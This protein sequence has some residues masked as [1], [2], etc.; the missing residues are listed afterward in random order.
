VFRK[1]RIGTRIVV[2]LALVTGLLALDLVSGLFVLGRLQS[3]SGAVLRERIPNHLSTSALCEGQADAMRAV[4]ALLAGNLPAD[5]R[6]ELYAQAD[7]AF[8]RIDAAFEDLG[9]QPKL[10]DAVRVWEDLESPWSRWRSA[11]SAALA[12]ERERD[13]IAPESPERAGADE[14]V[15]A[16][17]LALRPLHHDA[18]ARLARFQALAREG[19]QAGAGAIDSLILWSGIL[20]TAFFGV[21]AIPGFL[22]GR[23][24]T[25]TTSRIFSTIDQRLELLAQGVLSERLTESE[26]PDFDKVRDSL[27]G[28]VGSLQSLITEMNRMSAAHD[29]GDTDVIIDELRFAGEYRTVAQGLNRMVQAHVQESRKAIGIF[30]EFG[31]GNFDAALEPLPGKKRVINETVDQ[32]RTSL[33]SLIAEMNRMS[34]EHERGEIDAV[35]DESRFAGDY[36]TMARGVNEMVGAHLAVKRKALAAFTEFG[37]GNFDAP[38]EPLPGKRRFINDAVEQVRTNLR[39]LVADA[40]SLSRAA[41]EGRLDVRADAD[42]QSGGFRSI[43]QGVNETLDALVAPMREL[44]AVLERLAAGDLSARTDP[45]RYQNEARRLLEGVNQTLGALLAPVNEATRV[46]ARLAERDLRARMEGSYRGDHAAMKQALNAT[47]AVLDEALAQVSEAASHVSGASSQI[48]SSAAAVASGASEQAVSLAETTETIDAVSSAARQSAE[49]AQQASGLAKGASAAAREGASA[50]E[51]MK[52]TMVRIRSSAEGTSQIIRDIN[53]I[54]FQTNLLALNAAVEAA[55]AGEAGRGFAVVAEEV[56]SLALRAKEAATKTEVLIRQ[57]VDETGQGEVASRELAGKLTEILSGVGKVSDIVSEISV[58][59]AQQASGF[60]QVT[61]AVAEMDRITQQNAA[62]A[63]ESSSAA[64]EL[65]G[66]AEELAAM[67][68]TFRLSQRGGAASAR[69]GAGDGVRD[70]AHR[71]LTTGDPLGAKLARARP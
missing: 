14:R 35:I 16:A 23:S 34:A 57:S 38:L 5:F 15:L 65:S 29:A 19:M 66:Q 36:R 41:V 7:S 51:H 44:A 3:L 13:R 9:R 46:L 39:A 6:E 59:A 49:S 24:L 53:D 22:I 52:A 42:R 28:V 50:V 30:A 18:N 61:R 60:E 20:L 27:N 11:A 8:Q 12:L 17:V 58:A 21:L 63:E 69:N 37:R 56:R 33:R 45:S 55:R 62:S 26:G 47:A 48:A 40:A 71:P 1:L 70:G 4:Q 64:T 54:A 43:V 25:L 67:A 31:R 32:V 68:G 10:S 2:T